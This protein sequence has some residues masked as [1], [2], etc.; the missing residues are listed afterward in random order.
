MGASVI[1]GSTVHF[2]LSRS[3]EENDNNL[4]PMIPL[5][6]YNSTSENRAFLKIYA[7]AFIPHF[8][9]LSAKCIYTQSRKLF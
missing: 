1:G 2:P 7:P 5:P 6:P 3:S 4:T 8:D 9:V